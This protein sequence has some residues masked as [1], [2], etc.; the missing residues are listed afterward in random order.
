MIDR[1][2]TAP[3]WRLLNREENILSL[4]EPITMM[5]DKLDACARDECQLLDGS[6]CLFEGID[7]H[8][9]VIYDALFALSPLDSLTQTFLEALMHGLLLI[10][11]RQVQ[12]Q[13]PG[14]K[15]FKPSQSQL[16]AAAN[17]PTSNVVS[18]RDF[19][20][21]DLLMRMKLSAKTFSLEALI[22]WANNKTSD[23]LKQLKD[24]DLI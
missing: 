16:T 9:D 14:G 7:I 15:Y 2:I 13:L 22:M 1:L 8:M 3:F 20:C 18:E 11:E 4:N 12:D 19:G 21:L 24:E 23:W 10:L 17:V 5:R 6:L